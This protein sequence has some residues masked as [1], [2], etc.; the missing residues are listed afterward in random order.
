MSVAAKKHLDRA[1]G[2]HRSLGK[3]ALVAVQ[4]C[5]VRCSSL[6]EMGGAFARKEAVSARVGGS[7]D[8]HYLGES[9]LT[10]V[11]ALHADSLY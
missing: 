8:S 2:L 9:L 7:I 10:F 6:D 4:G 11:F 1:R 5:Q 3:V